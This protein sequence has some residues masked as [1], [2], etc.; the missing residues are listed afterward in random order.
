MRKRFKWEFAVTTAQA[1]NGF[2]DNLVAACDRALDLPLFLILGV[3][4]CASLFLALAI[5][6]YSR[7]GCR[8]AMVR[9]LFVAE[10]ALA[11]LSVAF[12]LDR[13]M[14]RLETAVTELRQK[15]SA[16]AAALLNAVAKLETKHRTFFC[17]PVEVQKVLAQ[18]FG[19]VSLRPLIYDEATDI[20]QVH[21]KRPLLQAY[22]AVVDLRNPSLEIKLGV[23]LEKKKL[24][25]VF[26]RETD[27]T[28]A[29]NGEA[30]NSPAPN[31]GLGEW[32]GNLVR[33]GEV[34]L[35]ENP[36]IPAPFLSFD[37]QNHA[38]FISA[39]ATN[40]YLPADA[41]NVIWGRW[42][43]L[44]D[45]VV[46][47]GDHGNRQPRTGMA[48]N[49]DG[50]LLILLVADG[51]QPRYSAGLTREAAGQC[52]KAFGGCNGMLCDEGGSSCIY[53]KQFGGIASIPADGYGQ[54]RPTYTHFGVRL[55]PDK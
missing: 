25:S 53:L 21:L 34:L 45:G 38:Q 23:T 12:V 39:A 19:D 40:R 49:K 35:R 30:G 28:V 7:K 51:R 42:D 2:I 14:T 29:I 44:V 37:Q 31:S 55:R 17:D 16:D 27:C 9:G 15:T 3:I 5:Y 46:Q 18:Q 52:M 36:R 20:V 43:S 8:P 50:T 4:G 10:A 24:T 13:K 1:F 33:L 6:L 47:K 48:I 22:V 41:Y 11:V 54:E 26:A 32:R